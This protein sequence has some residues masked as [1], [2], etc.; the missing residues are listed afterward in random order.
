M[1]V[2]TRTGRSHQN[3]G[4]TRNSEGPIDKSL[5]I[6]TCVYAHLKEGRNSCISSMSAPSYKI[7]TKLYEHPIP[8]FALEY[9]DKNKYTDTLSSKDNIIYHTKTFASSLPFEHQCFILIEHL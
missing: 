5:L 7:K 1:K 2:G 3:F 8:W 6:S 9:G 4:Q